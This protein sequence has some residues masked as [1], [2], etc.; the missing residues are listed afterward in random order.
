MRWKRG[1]LWLWVFGTVLWELF[2]AATLAYYSYEKG[3][4]D[5]ALP[6]DII[7]L[8]F[9]LPLSILVAVSASIL[10]VWTPVRVI[11][12]WTRGIRDKD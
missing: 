2:L 1:L 4:L 5:K 9:W 3:G 6:D 7:F 10:V 12:G 11:I 8:I